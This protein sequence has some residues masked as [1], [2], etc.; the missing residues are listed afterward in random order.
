MHDQVV[1]VIERVRQTKEFLQQAMDRRCGFHVAPAHHVGHTLQGIINDDGK[2]ITGTDILA[3]QDDI[4]LFSR[5]DDPVAV[6]LALEQWFMQC[7]HGIV[8][9]Q[10][11][12][13]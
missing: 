11:Q 9:F 7:R 1:V 12:G 8:H 2:M 13:E 4:T 6:I 3:G 10:A 5:V